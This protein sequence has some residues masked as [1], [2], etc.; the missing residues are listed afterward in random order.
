MLWGEEKLG[1][2]GV[3]GSFL[4]KDPVGSLVYMI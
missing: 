2:F 4:F 3:L 1:F